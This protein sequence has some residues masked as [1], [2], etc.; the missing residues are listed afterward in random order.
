MRNVQA[1]SQLLAIVH[2]RVCLKVEQQALAPTYQGA[3]PGATIPST[4]PYSIRD[5]PDAE[6]ACRRYFQSF[7][8]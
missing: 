2:L 8:C 4:V 1:N 6:Y 7:R 3:L 5:N